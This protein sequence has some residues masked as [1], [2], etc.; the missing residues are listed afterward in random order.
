MIKRILYAI[1]GIPLALILGFALTNL[2]SAFLG[3]QISVA[4]WIADY[5]VLLGIGLAILIFG[6]LK[7]RRKKRSK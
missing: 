7:P 4:E 2:I 5:R 1:F 3:G 6:I